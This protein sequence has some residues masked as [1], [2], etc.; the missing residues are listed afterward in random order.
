MTH[1]LGLV[2]AESKREAQQLIDDITTWLKSRSI[3]VVPEEAIGA[4]D[5]PV[6]AI[7]VLGGDGLMM[8]MA[9]PSRMC[10]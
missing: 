1:R 5:P 10:P 4:S 7:I 2:A 8:R 9:I 3:T 6:D